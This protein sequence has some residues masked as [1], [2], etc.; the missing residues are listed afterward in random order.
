MSNELTTT[1]NNNL[2]PS[3]QEFN[4]FQVMARTAQASGLYGG[5]GGEAKIFMIL[6]AA[7]ELG[8]PPMV[9]LNGGLWNIQGKIEIS[10]RLMN[11]M[12][13]RGGHT[14]EITS[15]RE[16]CTIKA[17]R[18]DTGE[19]HTE[20]F[21]WSM[22][23]QAGLAKGNVWQKYP[24]DMLYNRCMSRLAR[25]LFPDVI[26]TAY[27]EG[28]IREAKEVE[29]FAQAEYEDLTNPQ[30]KSEKTEK[31]SDNP[32]KQHLTNDTKTSQC[33]TESVSCQNVPKPNG[34]VEE[35]RISEDQLKD[36]KELYGLI[37]KQCQENYHK[38]IRAE[39][40]VDKS[41]N[42]PARAYEPLKHMMGLNIELNVKKEKA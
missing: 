18:K 6:L 19:E 13:R 35:S 21:T 31:L 28:E 34:L 7:R 1:S 41:E 4:M 40:K 3:Q 29:T 17:K 5:V 25:R 38:I 22:A 27:V 24:E 39:F 33:D 37:D 30:V 15:T 11:S 32:G 26:G 2:L 14:M 12:I 9:A 42:L 8:I 20:V 23:E 36:L 16:R 10:A